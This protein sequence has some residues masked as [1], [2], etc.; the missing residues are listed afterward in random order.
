MRFTRIYSLFLNTVYDNVFWKVPRKSIGQLISNWDICHK[1]YFWMTSV[2]TVRRWS[3]LICV[4][5]N[6][7]EIALRWLRRQLMLELKFESNALNWKILVLLRFRAQFG[8][9]TSACQHLEFWKRKEITESKFNLFFLSE[10]HQSNASILRTQLQLWSLEAVLSW[11]GGASLSYGWV[12]YMRVTGI[13][14]KF[15][16]KDILRNVILPCS[17][18]V[19]AARLGFSTW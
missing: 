1:W 3:L 16:Y 7:L 14:D 8:S 6:H 11:F 10:D 13:M 4:L 18:R 9:F 2:D 17:C 12:S 5:L 19:K 15:Q